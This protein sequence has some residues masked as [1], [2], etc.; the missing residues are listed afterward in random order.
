LLGCAESGGSPSAAAFNEF[1][2]DC[3][4]RA[5]FGQRFVSTSTMPQVPAGAGRR[6]V[7]QS[8]TD[9]L[10][11]DCICR[12]D[13]P[14]SRAAREAAVQEML[15]QRTFTA[16]S[17]SGR[18]TPGRRSVTA[19]GHDR[20]TLSITASPTGFA[21]AGPYVMEVQY[22]IT[23]RCLQSFTAVEAGALSQRNR[24]FLESVAIP[25]AR[26]ATASAPNSVPAT[27]GAQ[28]RLDEIARLRARGAI[29]AQEYDDARRRIISGL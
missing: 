6:A 25:P 9:A 1:P 28:E 16:P 15:A 14:M 29:T 18:V 3:L 11:A 8:Q 2:A 22:I 13:G 20:V 27:G 5:D 19:Q 7:A 24:A 10:S 26:N 12:Q 21:V 4:Y 23:E 17:G